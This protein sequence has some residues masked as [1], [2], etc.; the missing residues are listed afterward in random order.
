MYLSIDD[1]NKYYKTI[2]KALQT[3]LSI[4][5]FH[6]LEL[7]YYQNI[8]SYLTLKV[9]DSTNLILIRIIIHVVV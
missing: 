7:N 9:I 5:V 1:N 6:E 3:K 4:V 2:N 8:F